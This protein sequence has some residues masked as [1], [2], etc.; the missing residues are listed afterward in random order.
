VNTSGFYG[1]LPACGDF[2]SRRL[3]RDFLEPWD[4]WLQ[5]A[6]AASREQLA[7]NWLPQYLTSPLWRFALNAGAC[8]KQAYAG[9]LMPSVDRVGRYY[10]LTISVALAT[11]PKLFPLV[12]QDWFTETERVALS[13]LAEGCD[14]QAFDG[15]V[16]TLGAPTSATA[17]SGDFPDD[18]TLYCQSGG[19]AALAEIEAES[20]SHFLS[21]HFPK[22]TLWWS[23]GSP[24]I[25][26]CLLIC[27]GLPPA[28]GFAAMLAGDWNRWGWCQ[29]PNRGI[30]N[31][32]K[33]REP[34]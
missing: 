3:G 11:A 18:A 34:I 21:R 5:T 30:A 6:I 2:V 29:L 8:G 4:R 26:P 19:L 28:T 31:L 9:I 25:A 10:P 24:H 22:Y 32:T 27:E 16:L 13:G 15:A 1:K 33:A 12:Q 17:S 20:A 23:K 14:L 7:E